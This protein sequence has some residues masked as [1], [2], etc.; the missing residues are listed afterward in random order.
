M[1][2][3]WVCRTEHNEQDSGCEL[4]ILYC[5]V[6]M[7]EFSPTIKIPAAISK[8]RARE[9]QME[10]MS[11]RTCVEPQKEQK[12]I[13]VMQ[14]HVKALRVHFHN[15]ITN[16]WF[17]SNLF[18]EYPCP[19]LDGH[20]DPSLRVYLYDQMSCHAFVN[21]NFPVFDKMKHPD[22][23]EW[24]KETCGAHQCKDEI[25]R[26]HTCKFMLRVP[27]FG[28]SRKFRSNHKLE[29]FVLDEVLRKVSVNISH[30]TPESEV[31]RILKS[32]GV[33]RLLPNP[34]T[35]DYEITRWLDFLEILFIKPQAK[36]K[37]R[38][39]CVFAQGI[40][41]RDV[42]LGQGPFER[43]KFHLREKFGDIRHIFETAW[44]LLA[45]SSF[46]GCELTGHRMDQQKYIAR[47]KME[48][49]L[50]ADQ[51][52]FFKKIVMST[53]P[54]RLVYTNLAG[55]VLSADIW[56]MVREDWKNEVD[57]SFPIENERPRALTL[58][59]CGQTAVVIAERSSTENL[60]VGDVDEIS[61]TPREVKDDRWRR[62]LQLRGPCRFPDPDTEDVCDVISLQ[63]AMD[64]CTGGSNNKFGPMYGAMYSVLMRNC[65]IHQMRTR[66]NCGEC[67]GTECRCQHLNN[68]LAQLKKQEVAVWCLSDQGCYFPIS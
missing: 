36:K 24:F 12:T 67:V 25:G 18:A 52:P 66:K 22:A 35:G 29:R 23:T 17:G 5:L 37:Q 54:S 51:N 49:R 13:D 64:Y 32:N 48:M 40:S 46:R 61:I 38:V 50:L 9:L 57:T 42:K 6:I 47:Y 43:G 56:R 62:E 7:T 1:C 65:W 39:L 2:E 27:F 11:K 59:C 21:P 68:L 19:N 44:V 10:G 15:D 8:R 45:E 16:F 53:F 3:R 63:Q 60:A 55:D 30:N 33:Q 14:E 58:D 41:L 34:S 4:N 20:G 26:H 31:C 28:I